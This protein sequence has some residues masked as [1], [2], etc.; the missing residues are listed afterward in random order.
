MKENKVITAYE[1]IQPMQREYPYDLIIEQVL[2]NSEKDITE[3]IKK[4]YESP[5]WV[6]GLLKY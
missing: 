5:L 6:E 1:W 2:I 4:M 3:E